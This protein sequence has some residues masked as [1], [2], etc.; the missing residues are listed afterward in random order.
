MI[1]GDLAYGR[2]D[3]MSRALGPEAGR[4][5]QVVAWGK[6]MLLDTTYAAVPTGTAPPTLAAL[7]SELVAHY[8]QV[9]PIF[10]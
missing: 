6:P 3:W 1:G 8:A 7:R 5:E 4:L 10:A 2:A 9:G